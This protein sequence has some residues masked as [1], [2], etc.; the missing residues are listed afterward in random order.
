MAFFVSAKNFFDNA[1]L[2][3]QATWSFGLLLLSLMAIVAGLMLI[4]RSFGKP[5]HN[6]NSTP[7][8][9]ASS[10]QRYELMARFWHWSLFGM[11]LALLISGLAFYAPSILP[12]PAPV[13]GVDWYW[14]HLFFGVLFVVGVLSHSLH[15]FL[16]ELD[17]RDVWFSRHDWREFR[18]QCAY[19]LGRGKEVPRTGKFTV[20]NKAFHFFLALLALLMCITGISLSLDTLGWM[21]IDQNWQ[22]VQRV[23]HDVGSWGFVTVLVAHVIWQIVHGNLASM[24]HGRI[25]SERL[26]AEFDLQQWQPQALD[27]AG[28]IRSEAEREP[29]R[30]Q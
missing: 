4:R 5:V 10:Y 1:A 3:Q 16:S 17:P 24:F 6:R 8:P 9:V 29:D 15:G 19:Y 7:R 28:H 12:G 20:S 25:S 18:A 26:G 14:V 27:K 30:T 23:L 22:R 13:I 2:P 21:V 11:L